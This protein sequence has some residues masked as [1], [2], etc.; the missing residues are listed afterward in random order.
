MSGHVLGA[1]ES[2]C[3]GSNPKEYLNGDK[4]IQVCQETGADAVYP[5]YGFLSENTEFAGKC[6][7]AG[8]VFVG[9]SADIMESFSQKHT[10]RAIAENAGVPILPGT[11][12][13]TCAEEA[14]EASIEIGLPVLLKA[15]G[16]G[17]GIGIHICWTEDDVTEKFK[18]AVRQGEAAFGDS[19]VFVE[20]YVQNAR[21]IEIQ[22]FG[23]GQGNIITFPE[24]ECSIQRRHQKV[25]EETPS[26]F[27]HSRPE[28]RRELQEAAR[29]LGSAIKYRSAGTVEYILDDDSGRFYFLEVNCRL[30]VEHGITEMVSGVD[31]VAWQLQL[32]GAT[33]SGQDQRKCLPN[34]DSSAP[35]NP[36]GHAIE[37]R[38]CA[39]DPAHDYR[40]CTGIIGEVQWPTDARVDTYIAAGVEVSAY[41][42]SLLAKLMVYSAVDRS[43]AIKKAQMALERTAIK[44]VITNLDL[45]RNI[46]ASDAFI[47]GKT[48]TKFL[49]SFPLVANAFIE[50]LDGGLMT[51]VQDYPGRKRM[52][53][54][55]VPPSG[56]MDDLSHRIANALVGNTT[57]AATLEV[58][59]TG[60]TFKVSQETQIA[61]CGMGVEATANGAVDLPCWKAIDL[62]AGS[63]VSIGAINKGS[64][65]Y[66]AF[67]GGVDVPKYLGSRSTFPGGCFGGHQGRAL[68]AGDIIPLTPSNLLK[69]LQEVPK[70]L[71]PNFPSENGDTWEIGVLPGPQSAPDYFTQEDVDEFFA[72]DFT[73][74][75]NS[76]RLGIRL[77]GPK[78]RFARKDGGDGGSHPSNVHDHVYAIGAI[79]YT[80]DMPVVL[81]V[82]GPSLGGFVCP[83]TV[84]SSEMWKMGQVRPGDTI[85]F[86]KLSLEEAAIG[87][88]T[89]E[90]MISSLTSSALEIECPSMNEGLAKVAYPP[91]EAILLE[92]PATSKSPK[93]IVR[94][95]G[96]RYIFVE[97]GPMELDLNLRVRV[98]L[99]E[100]WF[101]RNPIDGFVEASPGVRS[102]MIE[103]NPD[104]LHLKDLLTSVAHAEQ[105]LQSMAQTTE[106]QSR[107]IHLPIA[108]DDSSINDAIQ[109]Y[110]KS[111]RS[112][113]PY[114]PSNIDFVAKNNGIYQDEKSF[115]KKTVL[116]ASY[117]VLGLGDV[118]LGAPCAVPVDPRHRLVVPKYNPARTF[119]PEGAVGIGGSYMCIYPMNSPGGY[120]LIGRTLPIWNMFPRAGPFE[121]EK[122]WLLR[123]F[124]RIQYYEVS[125]QELDSL[126]KDFKNGQLSIKIDQGMFSMEEYNKLVKDVSTETAALKARQQVAMK[127]QMAI[128]AEQLMFVQNEI[129]DCA[130]D[131][132]GAAFRGKED[133]MVRSQ[134]TGTVWEL[135][136]NSGDQVSKGET[137]M[138]LEAMKMEYAVSAMRDGIVT[139]IG[140]TV[141]DMVQQGAPLCLVE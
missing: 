32:Q 26:P 58:T 52:W 67:R 11:S 125:E 85:R 124:D 39:E 62:S 51:S 80:G 95:A 13:L 66:I 75:H 99:L 24:R 101:D 46:V 64:R 29:A 120:Q 22:I 3:L 110:T 41:Y 111:I 33:Y 21:H 43:D 69:N 130:D 84:V 96:D 115:V 112:K 128:D 16:G 118:Y 7:D 86:K 78:P 91:T 106:L 42:D 63:V 6:A 129:Q 30:Q 83:V 119:T 49:Q 122:P 10:A 48:T 74:H 14:L 141:G 104:L 82:D 108:F 102:L 54:V 5:G 132:N 114:L 59:L 50:I 127:E 133:A 79:N 40:P 35:I 38:I 100:E 109:K 140:V 77:Q 34:F 89:R 107:V 44:G 135:K 37:C 20:K 57:E 136:R 116:E 134:V 81:T 87:R 98:K 126:R 117:M 94:L 103:Y 65:A 61:I 88:A 73:V 105:E 31:L 97:Y 8:I 121:P 27:V 92:I 139:H 9:P 71:Q 17:G 47:E 90:Q 45:A 12:L 60:P 72:T 113:A 55:G 76:N 1:R 53:S 137:I 28:L 25:I 70:P 123:N 23:D 131:D 15:T 2:Y 19:G 18:S 56:P 4:L 68:R 93:V 36:V 138:V